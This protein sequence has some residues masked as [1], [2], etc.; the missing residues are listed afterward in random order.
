MTTR[1]GYPGLSPA[2]TSPQRIANAVN[3]LA[4]GKINAV[5]DVT[6]TANSATTVV[7]DTRLTYFSFIAF[8]PVTANARTAFAAGEPYALL[9][10]RNR[11]AYTLTHTNNAQVDRTFRMLIIG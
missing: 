2:D 8:D 3:G 10:D 5:L 11:G 4:L 9:A 6:L 1:P 7:T